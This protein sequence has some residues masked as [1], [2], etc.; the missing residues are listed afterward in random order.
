[1]PDTEWCCRLVAFQSATGKPNGRPYT[2]TIQ[3]SNDLFY[4]SHV[5][6]Y[7]NWRMPIMT[8]LVSQWQARPSRQLTNAATLLFTVL[9]PKNHKIYNV[10]CHSCIFDIHLYALCYGFQ[11]PESC[12]GAAVFWHL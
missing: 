10:M 5:A 9:Y 2:D 4:I 6:L 12:S 11:D 1:M 8:P 3:L 7:P